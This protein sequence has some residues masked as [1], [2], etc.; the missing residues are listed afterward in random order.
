MAQ[1]SPFDERSRSLRKKNENKNS[2]KL[3]NYP[4]RICKN[5]NPKE[6][7]HLEWHP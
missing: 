7:I 4:K 3:R 6:V 1:A 2:T 5:P